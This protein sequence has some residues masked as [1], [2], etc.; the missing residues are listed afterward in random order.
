[1]T[2]MLRGRHRVLPMAIDRAILLPGQDLMEKLDERFRSNRES[3]ADWERNR[4]K[5]REEERGSD[6][7]DEQEQGKQDKD[8]RSAT[9]RRRDEN[10][11]LAART[12]GE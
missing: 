12:G 5:I 4:Q 2:V 8:L 6:V 7:E 1:M 11:S 3:G 10:E 9:E